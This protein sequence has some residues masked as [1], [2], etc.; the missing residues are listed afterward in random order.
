MIPIYYLDNVLFLLD[1]KDEYPGTP[2]E[3]QD[4]KAFVRFVKNWIDEENQ[5]KDVAIMGAG[6]KKLLHD[7]KK[8]LHYVEAAGGVV[9][10]RDNQLLFIRRWN[11]WDLPKGKVD[12]KEAAE[13]CALREVEEETGVSGLQIT[14]KLPSSFH[15]YYYKEKLYLKKTFWF[16]METEYNGALKPQLEEDISE[17]KWLDAE[18]CREAFRQTYRSLRD[19]LQDPVCRLYA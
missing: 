4:K 15:F 1:E 2:I 9:R 18:E 3:F 16:W 10:H 6:E 14:G 7:L 8:Q 12:G 5:R 17:V 13:D 11:I 19:N